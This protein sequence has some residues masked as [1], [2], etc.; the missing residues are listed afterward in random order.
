MLLSVS[1]TPQTAAMPRAIMS[2]AAT[3]SPSVLSSTPTNGATNVD[4]DTA[5]TLS[6]KLPNGALDPSTVNASNVTLQRNSDGANVASIVNTTGG[7]DAIVLTPSNF[8]DANTTYKLTVSANV[9][10]VSGTSMTP[11]TMT[12][13]TGSGSSAGNLNVAFQQVPLGTAA[14]VAFTCVR[15]GPDGLLYASSEDGRIFRFPINADGTLGVPQVISSLQTAN[16]NQQRLITG[17]AF[18]PASTG[19][20]I[21]L[22]VS[23]SFYGFQNVPDFTGKITVMSGPN[24]TTVQD[25]VINLPRSIQDHSTEQ[26]TFGPDGALYFPQGS[27][28]STGAPDNTWGNRSEHQLSAAILR[29]DTSKITP[30]KPLDAKTADSGGSYNPFAA[31]APLTI[32]A[33]GVRNSF[34]LLWTSNGTLY[35]PTN[36]A[37]SG[38]N[39]PAFPNS[40]NG[41]RIDTHQNYT[42]PAVPG[43][44]GITETE[45]DWLFKI[46]KGGYYGHPNPSRGEYLLDG[47]NPTAGADPFEFTEYPVGTKPDPNYRASDVY[48]LGP[49]R[50]ADG[51]LEYQDKTFGGLLQ[52]ALFIAD[53]SAGNDISILLRDA[54]GNITA[55]LHG[56]SGLTNLNNPV[57]IVEDPNTGNI[58]VAELGG[59]KLVLLKPMVPGAHLSASASLVAMNSIATGNSGAG[60]SAA[61]S[62]TITNKGNATLTFGTASIVKDPA[63]ATNDATAFQIVSGLPSSLAPGQSGTIQVRF[64][65]SRVGVE[66]ALLQIP[67][68]DVSTATTTITL[69]GLG[70]AGQFS[71]LEPS[72]QHILDLYEIPDNVGDPN[73]NDT[74]Y[75]ATPTQPN[76]EVDASRFVKAGNGPV[77]V[78]MLASFGIGTP[79]VSRM[80]YYTAGSPGDRTE[81]FS[82][83]QNDQQ[84]VDPT[85]LGAT[86]FDPGGTAFGLFAAFP[87]FTDPASNGSLTAHERYSY[88]E[89]AFN[90]SWDANNPR[91]MRAYPLKNPDG[92]VVPNAYVVAFEDYNLAYDSN[93]IVAII[94]NVS[95]ASGPVIGLENLD[96]TPA[97]DHLVFNRI[98]IPDTTTTG[99]AGD[100]VHDTDTLR[101]HNTGQQP[102][103]ITALTLSD[104]SAWQIVN[105]PSLPVTVA[106]NNG[107]LDLT[108]K[109]IATK[110]PAHSDNQTNDTA[111]TNGI[112]P[113]QAGGVYSG[114][115]T[116]KTAD[117]SRDVQLTGY[118][119]YQSA[120]ENEPSLQTLTNKVFGYGT[121]INS[122]PIAD[123]TEGSSAVY[124]GEEYH[125]AS[126]QGLFAAADTSKP[127]TVQQ[128]DAFHNQGLTARTLWYAAG[129]STQTELFHHEPNA[130]Q[131]LLP[132][133]QGTSNSAIATFTSSGNF[134]FNLDGE[135]SEDSRNTT[136]K[137]SFGRSGHAVRVYPL[138]DG[139]NRLIPNTWLMVMD[140]QNSEFDND[141]F[142]DLM[143]IVSNMRPAALPPT[144]ADL[145]GTVSG[146]GVMLQW[147]PANFSGVS[148]NV[149]RSVNGAAPTT[150]ASALTQASFTDATAPSGTTGIKYYV[151]ANASGATSMLASTT[152]DLASGSVTGG[153]GGGGNGF[154]V[155]IGAGQSFKTVRFTDA[156]GTLVTITWHG[157]G[158]AAVSFNGTSIQEA[159]KKGIANL[160][161]TGMSISS[162]NGTGTNGGSAITVTTHG[163]NGL[164]DLGSFN[165]DGAMKAVTAKTMNLTG[166]LSA[167][168][169]IAHLLLASAQNG[170]ITLG[171]GAPAAIQVGS[172]TSENITSGAPINS[173]ISNNW[174]SP[175]SLSAPSVKQIKIAHDA[176]FS[177]SAAQLTSLSVKGTLHDSTLTLTGPA[178][179]A[180]DVGSLT[181]GAVTGTTINSTGNIK[182]VSAGSMSGSNVYAGVGTLAAGQTLPSKAS[183]FTSQATIATVK[184]KPSATADF[185]NS[186]IAAATL[187]H[188]SLGTASFANSGKPFGVVGQRISSLSATDAATHK[189]LQLHNVTIAVSLSNQL[190]AQGIGLQDM[191]IKIV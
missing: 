173:I 91:K 162:I 186:N 100:I 97:S 59:Q 32:Y 172:A 182:M 68:N 161:G 130:A 121:N 133:I 13:T 132:K 74:V 155:N 45:D 43:L 188:L 72:F 83:G 148:Y 51:I 156:D 80:G 71:N 153:G 159:G 62:I 53:Y 151:T 124:Y 31:N 111:T 8:L 14:G 135:F 78:Q 149:L 50:S 123:L 110:N 60:P 168:G 36:G 48:D 87:H 18:D 176:S 16:G 166:N 107:T 49:H 37:S 183:D 140:Y 28:N 141:D 55:D 29:L 84:T 142:Q 95:P 75:P 122:T 40:V 38:G 9:K 152:V 158:S 82:L 77:T 145:Q 23:N 92:S 115:L 169:S 66:S 117:T 105:A 181:A 127:V 187:N 167:G 81:L 90:L 41:E 131:S 2:A 189:H 27:N 89:D 63:I 30:G 109:F 128:I 70:T 134:G 33:S 58:Y 98:N 125:A 139:S 96:E 94:R 22:W 102:L 146:A 120:H 178:T 7:G 3:S 171:S 19:S 154:S 126:Q 1:V 46:V 69:R 163:G 129:S 76:D 39:A 160:A 113:E 73:P 86:S 175:S 85:P 106:A 170:S 99:G 44:T 61:Q 57:N 34:Q 24:L 47:G 112:A 147:S 138:R 137:N 10:D 5:V 150:L 88:S 191:V 179:S 177:L 101:I 20:N 119:Q 104:T 67:S 165:A 136:D 174:S 6:V 143:Y 26:P 25:A 157:A 184:I 65:A 15:I 116:I 21:K 12:F 56:L 164:A 35:A 103:K 11:F 17:F 54:S 108:I 42:G 4:R 180:F 185:S 190:A 64:T 93:D 52:N 118:W 79:I 114:T 144:P